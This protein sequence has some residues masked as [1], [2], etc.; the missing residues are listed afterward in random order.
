MCRERILGEGTQAGNVAV[1]EGEQDDKIQRTVLSAEQRVLAESRL[2]QAGQ[3]RKRGLSVR[4]S[5]D[6]DSAGGVRSARR[7]VGT[8]MEGRT[9]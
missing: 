8:R 9:F 6:A 4:S 7:V 3:R 1:R 5:G 2:W